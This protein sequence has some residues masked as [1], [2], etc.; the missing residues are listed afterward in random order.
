MDHEPTITQETPPLP[1]R[2][3]D[4]HKGEV[5]RI[6]VIGGCDDRVM[7]VGA[8]ALA[9]NA[10]YRSG[11]GLVQMIVP[12]ALRSSVAVLAPCA[13]IRALP[14]QPAALLDMLKEFRADVL[15]LGPGLGNS[16][17]SS[18]LMELLSRFEGSIVLDADGLNLLATTEPFE[19]PNAHRVV[20]TPHVGEMHRLL[21]A[22]N[23]DRPVEQ[24]PAA[25]RG[26]ALA[27]VDA[28]HC[29]VVLKGHHT[30]VTDGKRL[31]R[32]QT[33]NAGMATG[34]MGDVLTGVIAALIGQ[35]LGSL[36]ASILG[37]YLHGLAG[38]FAAEELGRRSM[39]AM[40]VIEYL[41]EAFCEYETA[42]L[43]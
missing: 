1:H 30:I 15:A 32:N 36:E 10:A 23:L 12:H 19:I 9:A 37:V 20:V 29:V 14:D 13:T 43:E 33:G 8:V 16:I 34:G 28:Y 6:V 42:A 17:T 26:A 4:A 22:R 39:T 21:G 3:D 25:R 24:T 7:M 11:A 27:L 31:F 40:D 2:A 18:T 5:G 38:D 35:N 41:P